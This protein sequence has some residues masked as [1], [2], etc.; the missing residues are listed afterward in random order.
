MRVHLSRLGA[1]FSPLHTPFL[2]LGC[3]PSAH[4]PRPSA[5]SPERPSCP[6]VSPP[7][8]QLRA[9][10][11][12]PPGPSTGC[13]SFLWLY[14][15][16]LRSPQLSELK[17]S[18]DLSQCPRVRRPCVHL[19][20]PTPQRQPLP[21]P[22]PAQLQDPW[23]FVGVT[24]APQPEGDLRGS[25]LNNGPS[26]TRAPAPSHQSSDHVGCRSEPCG[27]LLAAL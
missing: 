21:A 6:Q 16:K 19:L 15:H 10:V 24:P 1:R 27:W 18:P 14:N 12:F 8:L 9:G 11:C 20:N 23:I 4:S 5:A 26:P 2:S 13:I 3:S 17:I 22:W 25:A 7:A